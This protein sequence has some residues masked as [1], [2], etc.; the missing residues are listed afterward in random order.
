MW[1]TGSAPCAGPIYRGRSTGKIIAKSALIPTEHEIEKLAS[2]IV[3]LHQKKCQK[4]YERGTI[5]IV[6][7]E[8]STFF[9]RSI[10]QKLIAAIDAKSDLS[11]GGFSE[12]HFFNC[13]SNELQADT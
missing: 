3:D 12:V 8:D 13:G 5:L 11:G 6:A 10:W 1:K 4:R 2:D 9:G 7:F